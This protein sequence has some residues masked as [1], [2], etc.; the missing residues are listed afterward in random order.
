MESEGQHQSE[1]Y[2]PL[3]D[4]G[5]NRLPAYQ[6][7]PVPALQDV[8]I[9]VASCLYIYINVRMTYKKFVIEKMRG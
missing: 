5:L 6:C 3:Y 8:V 1:R 7:I 2:W 4:E 9:T